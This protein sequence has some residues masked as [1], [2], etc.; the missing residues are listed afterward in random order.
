MFERLIVE[1]KIGS[2]LFYIFFDICC[3]SVS[4]ETGHHHS[5]IE[6]RRSIILCP[7][8]SEADGC[9]F[10]PSLTTLI[11]RNLCA[12]VKLKFSMRGL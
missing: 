9:G 1:D 11:F 2:L 6:K 10:E 5:N 7:T 12:K 4:T 8:T 3:S